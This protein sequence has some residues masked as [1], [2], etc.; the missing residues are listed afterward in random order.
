[1]T[2]ITRDDIQP[3]RVHDIRRTVASG[4]A[5][6]GI[7]IATIEKCLNH[8]S[9]TVAG[10]VGVYQHHDFATEKRMAWDAWE[11]HVMW[12]AQGTEAGDNP[13]P[14]PGAGPIGLQQT[15]LRQTRGGS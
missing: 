15:G 11:A 10:V 6:L 9:G 14:F 1:M 12:L 7:N 13:D 4:M 5:R 2:E 3:G 8:V